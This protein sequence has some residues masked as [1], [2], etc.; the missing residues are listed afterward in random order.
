MAYSLHDTALSEK[1][2]RKM[3]FRGFLY[4]LGNTGVLSYF[5][6]FGGDRFMREREGG[7]Y[8]LPR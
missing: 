5:S 1:G 2:N 8:W 6:T 3:N 7:L 4:S